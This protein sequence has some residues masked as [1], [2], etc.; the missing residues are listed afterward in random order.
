MVAVTAE[1]NLLTNSQG[2][3]ERF[4]RGTAGEFWAE[5]SDKDGKHASYTVIMDA[6]RQERKA[7]YAATV[8]L[9]RAVYGEQFD[10]TFSYNKKGKNVVMSL[11]HKIH[12][13]YYKLH[14][15]LT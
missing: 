13:H 12:E 6:L 10:R 4:R 14:P 3:V 2:F 7:D 11:P 15:K 5:F 1:I 8:N 9:A